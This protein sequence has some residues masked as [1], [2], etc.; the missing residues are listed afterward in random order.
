MRNLYLVNGGNWKF[1]LQDQN[2][3]S[4]PEPAVARCSQ[5]MRR[6]I[7][8]D[9]T[10]L[11]GY[12]ALP[13]T[14]SCPCTAEQAWFDSTYNL[15]SSITSR[16]TCATSRRRVHAF[17]DSERLIM[18]RMCCYQRAQW[19]TQSFTSGNTRSSRQR[20]GQGAL[21]DGI[22]GG[23]LIINNQ[24]DDQAAF[25]SCCVDAA[26]VRNGWYCDRFVLHRPLS[27]PTHPGCT[28]Y[29]VNIPWT[30]TSCCD[31]HLTTL[32]G[33]KYSFNGLGDF[34][35]ADVDNGEYQL[36]SR[37]S[38][39][40]GTEHAT[41]IT[42]IIAYQKEKQPIQIQVSGD[43][44]LEL[45]VNG[46]FTD[47]SVL[48]KEGYDLEVGD[49][50]LV[51]KPANNSLLVIFFSGITIQAS[52]RKGMLFIDFSSPP[53]FL[54]KIRGLLGKFDG[55]K[56][57]DFEGSDGV[58]TPVSAS[59]QQL[60]EDF[61]ITWQLTSEDGPRK[62]LFPNHTE[63]SFQTRSSFY[64]Q[65]TDAI[66]FIDPHLESQAYAI[67]KNNTECLFDISQ[68][69]DISYGHV[70]LEADEEFRYKQ[71]MLNMFP[72]TLN[73]PGTVYATV[74]T[75]VTVVITATDPSTRFPT[76]A[77]GPEVPDTVEL[78][79]RESEA[80]LIWQVTSASP[81]KLQVDVYNA[82][83]TT[84]Q[85]WP[86]VY[87]CSC[88]N[89]GNCD[90]S[91]D[92]DPSIAGGENKF[93]RRT[94]SC[95]PGYAGDDCGFQV[96]ACLVNFNPCFPGSECT[97]LP[98]PAGHGAD[99]YTCGP[100]PDGYTGDGINCQDRDECA[101]SEGDICQHVCRNFLGGFDCICNDGYILA[102]DDVSCNDFDE[103]STNANNCSQQ[104]T[105]TDGA[106]DCACR[107]GFVLAADGEDC[108]PV[109]PCS[110]A[111]NPGC[112]SEL[113]WCT[114][115]GAGTVECSCRKGYQLATDGVT[116]EDEDECLSGSH[117]CEQLCNN[118]AGG[119]S[120]YC[121]DG[122]YTI[123]NYGV[124]CLEID[125]C[126]EGYHNCT[127]HEQCVNDPGSFHCQCKE[128]AVEVNGICLPVTTTQQ[129]TTGSTTLLSSTADHTTSFPTT[130][131]TSSPIT[132]RP[133][134]SPAT[135]KTK[136]F[137]P[138]NQFK[139]TTMAEADNTVAITHP[140]APPPIAVT[141]PP[142][143]IVTSTKPSPTGKPTSH[144]TAEPEV[145][146]VVEVNT[147][148][149]EVWSSVFEIYDQLATFKRAM[150]AEV[151]TFCAQQV[152]RNPACRRVDSDR[153]RRS[154]SASVFL[155]EDVHVTEGYPQPAPDSTRTAL[156]FFM[157]Y[158]DTGDFRPVPLGVLTT[159]V[160]QSQ[161]SLEAA[162]NSKQITYIGSLDDYLDDDHETPTPPSSPDETDHVHV[163]MIYV[164]VGATIFLVTA[165]IIAVTFCLWVKKKSNVPK[166][167]TYQFPAV[168]LTHTGVPPLKQAWGVDN[169]VIIMDTKA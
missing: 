107:T 40:A 71:D 100:C 62:S 144:W 65:F 114:T 134:T 166:V 101:G 135:T 137:T 131:R 61:G 47:L 35:M 132:N 22:R 130:T 126:S 28:N 49:N 3:V 102:E 30:T 57:N 106:F 15:P 21:Q 147:I 162:L 113:G 16:P 120:C 29:R 89:G 53:E 123:E 92:P 81:F 98:P 159:V 138:S 27:S 160:Q 133:T 146:N 156:A 91:V 154:Y 46:S 152:D 24:A 73:G 19:W 50:A 33:N 69:G 38:L 12:D 55:D 75:T 109:S 11:F 5:W 4:P 36:Q 68:T 90:S 7:V 48:D 124:T 142:E 8:E 44:D 52:A 168:P 165:F 93:F 58:I 80:T 158:S 122:Y 84:A 103:C 118:T 99:G 14:Q 18:S 148:V 54:G 51:T 63:D 20:L 169:P 82:E 164:T 10:Q 129:V 6:Q 119:Y 23:H 139:T 1:A 95:A 2:N 60:Y 117:H 163:P 34:L 72:P 17:V 64:P 140:T 143:P 127:E 74:G 32:D 85:Y 121:R 79:V 31:P 78:R 110:S 157:V 112:D 86:V 77:L 25:Q 39:A 153:R 9:P 105:N 83:N 115:D 70:L 43:S 141:D 145:E 88:Q 66:T 155:P 149:I 111:D 59:E 26:A 104:C 37:M 56:S 94:C 97:D 167:D 151:T 116:C 67:C 41:I 96:D 136:P 108:E 150:A 125:E 45:Y 76:F 87:M 128:E 161:S 13:S 42:T